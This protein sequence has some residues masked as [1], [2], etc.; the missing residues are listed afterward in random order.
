VIK[1]AISYEHRMRQKVLELS[2]LYEFSKRISSASRLEDALDSILAIVSELI[3]NDE[4]A[5][6]AVEFERSVIVAKATRSKSVPCHLPTEQ[7]LD[8]ESITSWAI[9]ER[10]ALVSP[11]IQQDP[12][13]LLRNV[14]AVCEGDVVVEGV[15][16]LRVTVV[17]VRFVHHHHLS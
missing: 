15:L 4:C 14:V 3:D 10:K 7:P 9:R 16:H 13:Q 11:D 2:A 17:T 6:Y 5:I 1:N 8:S 12:V